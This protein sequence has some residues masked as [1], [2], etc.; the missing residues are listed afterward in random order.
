LITVGIREDVMQRSSTKVF[1][2]VVDQENA[3]SV[4]LKEINK[5]DLL[6]REEE[7]ELA[8]RAKEGDPQ[9][10]RAPD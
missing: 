6:T 7:V 2:R 4:Y 1:V 5:V 10:Q 8:T 3:L 9:G